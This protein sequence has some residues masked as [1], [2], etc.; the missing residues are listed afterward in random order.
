MLAISHEIEE[1]LSGFVSLMMFVVRTGFAWLASTGASH[2]LG[3]RLYGGEPGLKVRVWPGL[4]TLQPLSAGYT[5]SLKVALR[6][7]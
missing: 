4:R 6:H 7:A 2:H 5:G 3:I 1:A